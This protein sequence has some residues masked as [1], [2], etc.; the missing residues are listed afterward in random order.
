M[1]TSFLCP[2]RAS[3]SYSEVP[4]RE[5]TMKLMFINLYHSTEE[6]MTLFISWLLLLFICP[7]LPKK[8]FMFSDIN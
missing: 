1:D 8:Q 2:A 5:V 6:V 7:C 3:V 4:V